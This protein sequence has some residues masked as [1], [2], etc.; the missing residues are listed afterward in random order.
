MVASAVLVGCGGSKDESKTQSSTPDK[1]EVTTQAQ[2]QQIS[3]Q[4]SEFGVGPIQEPLNLPETIDEALAKKGEELFNSKGCTACHAL[5][6]RKVGPPLRDVVNKQKPEW[7]MNMIL[8]P[9][10][11][12]QKDPI[13]KK[14]LAEY[15]VPM[16]NQHLTKEEARAVLEF[17]RKAAK[18]KK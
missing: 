9:D 13:A 7:I 6:E 8:N 5:D 10:E 14:L 4:A 15:S 12:V 1:A 2:P 11:M 16:T 17:L 3:Q 18:E